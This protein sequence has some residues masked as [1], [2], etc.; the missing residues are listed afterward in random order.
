M[1]SLVKFSIVAIGG[2]AIG[3]IS[4]QKV[5]D[6]AGHLFNRAYGPWKGWPDAGTRAS[7]PYIRAHFLTHN[8]LPVSQFEVNE[9]EADSDNKGA[10]LDSDCTYKISANSIKA[11]WWSLYT[12]A[13][14]SNEAQEKNPRSAITSRSVMFNQNGGFSITLSPDAHPGNWIRP[15]G[16]DDLVLILRYYNPVRSVTKQLDYSTLPT[17]TRESCK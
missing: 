10:S 9:F 11:R 3:F 2:L 7:N 4:A 1:N 6:G 16:E 15:A 5:A 13:G 17:I 14:D 8:R 12:L